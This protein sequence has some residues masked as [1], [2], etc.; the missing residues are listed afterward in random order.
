MPAWDASPEANNSY[1]L[2]VTL[3]DSK[4][5]RVTSNWITLQVQPPVMLD[6]G[7]ENRFDLLAP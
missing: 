1:R 2:S 3:E 6:Q 7:D 5:N 4:Q